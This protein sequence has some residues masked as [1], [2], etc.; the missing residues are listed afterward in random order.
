[1]RDRE[2]YEIITI[3]YVSRKIWEWVGKRVERLRISDKREIN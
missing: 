1:M 2:M 3:A